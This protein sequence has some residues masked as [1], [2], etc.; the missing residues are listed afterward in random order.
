MTFGA[1]V[2]QAT[3]EC[4]RYGKS[5]KDQGCRVEE[6]VA[7][8][9]ESEV[10]ECIAKAERA[11]KQEPIN[12]DRIVT[13]CQNHK[14]ADK[15]GGQN[16]KERKSQFANKCRHRQKPGTLYRLWGGIVGSQHLRLKRN[17]ELINAQ[18]REKYR[19]EKH[20][21]KTIHKSAIVR[22]FS[23][24]DDVAASILGMHQKSFTGSCLLS[25][26]PYQAARVKSIV[27]EQIRRHVYTL[28]E[29]AAA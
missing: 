5:S 16:C 10:T 1:N 2:E 4:K 26:F 18:A 29:L 14:R 8:V 3:L 25:V 6:R 28:I 12:L 24:R 21:F 23:E 27:G 15:E 17:N 9:I 19:I 22:I 20:R 13:D 11:G 7:P